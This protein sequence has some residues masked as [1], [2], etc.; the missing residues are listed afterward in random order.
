MGQ[1]TPRVSRHYTSCSHRQQSVNAC[2]IIPALLRSFAVLRSEISA[3]TRF[4]HRR[5]YEQTL[6]LLELTTTAL[7][8][9]ESA[10][11]LTTYGK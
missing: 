6:L 1:L 2:R 11:N 9:F 5:R 8:R 7:S 3:A 4:C 10:K